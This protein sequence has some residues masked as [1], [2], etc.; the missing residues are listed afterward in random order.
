MFRGFDA[1]SSVSRPS[2]P[3]VGLNLEAISNQSSSF[4]PT[5]EAFSEDSMPSLPDVQQMEAERSERRCSLTSRATRMSYFSSNFPEEAMEELPFPPN[6]L[7][8]DQHQLNLA[9]FLQEVTDGPKRLGSEVAHRRR[10]L[11]ANHGENSLTLAS[12]RQWLTS[13]KSV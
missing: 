6:R 8:H 1:L 12:I 5:E 9:V 4:C 11:T 7:L 3:A 10:N 2:K 13:R